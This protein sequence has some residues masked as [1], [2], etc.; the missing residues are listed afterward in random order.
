MNED[1]INGHAVIA[2]AEIPDRA[3]CRP[4]MRVVLVDR[5]P[6]DNRPDRYVVSTAARGEPGWF[7]GHYI[8]DL[9]DARAKFNE[10][11]ERYVR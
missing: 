9:T 7:Q 2:S 10:L 6:S 11:W 8:T 4:N 1:T 5:G 3:G